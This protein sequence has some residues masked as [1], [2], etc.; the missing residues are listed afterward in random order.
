M[1]NE[2]MNLEGE[3]VLGY[4]IPF[5][6]LL[7]SIYN[8][9]YNYSQVYIISEILCSIIFIITL[10]FITN[11]DKINKQKKHKLRTY[12]TAISMFSGIGFIFF[13]GYLNDNDL[14]TYCLIIFIA[15]LVLT[16]SLY[17]A[18]KNEFSENNS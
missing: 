3:T 11:N 6:M 16:H 4:S 18:N 17:L 14:I 5:L 15:L 7:D 10:Y 8:Y 2:K 13:K 9:I 12:F 1:K